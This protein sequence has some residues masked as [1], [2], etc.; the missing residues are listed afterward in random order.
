MGKFNHRRGL[1]RVYAV[2]SIMWVTGALALAISERP[3]RDIFDV[4]ASSSD[5]AS[6]FFNKVARQAEPSYWAFHIAITV[7][8][9]VIGYLALFLAVPWIAR[10]FRNE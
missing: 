8:P 4:A 7:A 6:G 1:L 9:P 3:K 5:A 2:V 10:G